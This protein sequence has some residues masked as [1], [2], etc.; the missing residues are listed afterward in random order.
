MGIVTSQREE[1]ESPASNLYHGVGKSVKCRFV[2]KLGERR[3]AGG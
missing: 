2:T 1:E 3:K